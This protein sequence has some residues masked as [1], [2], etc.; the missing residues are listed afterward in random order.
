METKKVQWQS[1]QGCWLVGGLHDDLSQQGVPL[2]Q[3][4]E[5]QPDLVSVT[6][7]L[8]A[9]NYSTH[10]VAMPGV[11][12]RNLAKAL[13]FALEEF[14]I[15]DVDQ[16]L[17]VPAGKADK[18]VRAYAVAADL[19]ERLLQECELHH[20]QVRE[21]IPETSL[22]PQTHL[23]R[24]QG[25]G[26][27]LLLPGHFEGWIPASALTPVL[28]SLLDDYRADTLAGW[29]DGL[30]QAKMIKSSLETGFADVFGEIDLLASTCDEQIESNLENKTCSLLV[31]RYQVRETRQDK[32]AAWWS[33]LAALAAV[34]LVLL[35][36]Y[37][38]IDNSALQA[39]EKEVRQAA[40]AL[41]KQ[42]FPG[43]R[44]RSLDRQ[45]R[46]K[47]AGGGSSGDAGFIQLVNT[48]SKV[49][50][51]KGLQQK[52]Q[53]QS[54]RFSERLNELL[55]EVRASSLAELQQLKQALEQEGLSAEVASATNDK[56][57][58]KGRLKVGGAA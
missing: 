32:P 9:S 14:L 42:L 8:A 3:W 57:G 35:A 4:A 45:F 39:Q 1:A 51:A 56:N 38:F 5:G 6:L 28:E 34:W 16:Y 27:Q 17:V 41:Y 2:E 12:Q 49:Y 18:K 33:S 44:I 7:V 52:V 20:V 48:T 13:P 19:I 25:D 23:L 22:L 10:W 50:A 40:N 24:H 21:L 15:E 37:L 46:E 47:L 11:N 55:I 31:G 54:M 29:S 53:L 36:G 43:E 26:W 30:D 58:V